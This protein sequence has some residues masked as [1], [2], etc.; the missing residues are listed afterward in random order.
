M[1]IEAVL[2]V[3]A[4]GAPGALTPRP[5]VSSF[6]GRKRIYIYIYIYIYISSRIRKERKYPYQS[7]M[8]MCAPKHAVQDSC[9]RRLSNE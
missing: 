1:T 6:V 7:D 3:N 9:L 8:S 2:L 4:E 5:Q